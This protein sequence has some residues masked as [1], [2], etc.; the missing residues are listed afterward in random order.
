MKNLIIFIL[1]SPILGIFLLVLISNNEKNLLKF[2]ALN[3]SLLPFMGL[4][5]VWSFFNRKSLVYHKSLENSPLV[6]EISW[7]PNFTFAIDGISIYFLLLTTLLIPICILISLD[8]INYKLKKYLIFFLFLEFL[9]TSFFC[10]F[11][12]FI[13]FMFFDLFLKKVFIPIFLIDL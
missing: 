12:F 10:I 8:S 1:V 11:D 3:F 6:T 9:L 5:F 7:F 13:F 4:T 2:T